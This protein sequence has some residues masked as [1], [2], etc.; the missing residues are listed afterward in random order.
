M[1]CDYGKKDRE[2]E[3]RRWP[4]TG[5]S[6][7]EAKWKERPVDLDFW[8]GAVNLVCSEQISLLLFEEYDNLA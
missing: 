4:E 3:S 2:N 1:A 6:A 7:K 5:N 8:T